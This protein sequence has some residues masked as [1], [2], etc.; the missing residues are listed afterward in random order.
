VLRHDPRSNRCT[1]MLKSQLRCVDMMSPQRPA[2]RH[3]RV[4]ACDACHSCDMLIKISECS[5]P[6]VLQRKLTR[7]VMQQSKYF[8]VFALR[9]TNKRSH[10]KREKDY[11][12]CIY[13][14]YR[15][16][17]IFLGS[18]NIFGLLQ[19]AI[20]DR[21]LQINLSKTEEIVPFH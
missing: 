7:R 2:M 9:R 13:L 12:V 14:R 11:H 5:N 8:F 3:R 18:G 15:N 21:L 1:C 6:H 17:N 10:R 19:V 4:S 20:F 16:G